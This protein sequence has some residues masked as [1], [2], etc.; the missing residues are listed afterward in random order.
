MS[1]ARGPGVVSRLLLSVGML[2]AGLSFTCWWLSHTILDVSRT[3]RVTHAVLA[4]GDFRTFLAG[5]ISPMVGLTLPGAD[6]HAVDS[7]LADVLG[8][9]E[10]QTQLEGF[11]V[12]VQRNLL[13][14]T[15]APAVLSQADITR[16]VTA[17]LPDVPA[18]ELAA[19][20]GV[21]VNPPKVGALSSLRRLVHNK[22]G[23]L[24]ALAAVSLA[25]AVALS[26]N[27]RQ[28]LATVGRW[29]I[30]ISLVHLLVLWIIPVYLVPAVTSSPWAS[31]IAAVARALSSGLVT[32]LVILLVA[33]VGIVVADRVMK[34]PG[35]TAEFETESGPHPRV[36]RRA[37]T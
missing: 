16:I 34:K 2:L 26:R 21:S 9:P 1:R 37:S 30:G 23:L 6:Q 32:G 8:R 19:L 35:W 12:D 13:G 22:F 7:Q 10:V 25:A 29:L 36:V 15:D 33:G 5:K 14:E 4:D 24:V 3:Q 17:A 31:L 28:T 18:N 11:I 20:S 27:R